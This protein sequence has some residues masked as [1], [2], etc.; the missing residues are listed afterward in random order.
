MAL[1]ILLNLT[2]LLGIF[3]LLPIPPLDGASV[4]EGAAPRQLGRSIKAARDPVMSLL[5]LIIAW[6][7]FRTRGSGAEH[8]IDA[9]VQAS[10][11]LCAEPKKALEPYV[12][13]NVDVVVNAD[14]DAAL[15][16]S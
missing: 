10:L 12:V 11:A 9:A 16:K 5:G 1:S 14:A 2:V 6:G 8:G 3:N 13:V 15:F 7:I 4:L